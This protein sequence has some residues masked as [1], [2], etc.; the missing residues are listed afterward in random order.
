MALA[1]DHDPAVGG[2]G[3]VVARRILRHRAP[4]DVE[5]TGG[6][7]VAPH[8]GGPTLREAALALGTVSAEDFD[9]WVRPA[10]MVGG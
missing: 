1:L 7:D 8:D 2:A 4:D 3:L 5:V 9:R 6:M 10:E